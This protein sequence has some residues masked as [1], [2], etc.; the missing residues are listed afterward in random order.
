MQ[1][2][3][4]LFQA[5]AHPTRRAVL[6]CLP[7]RNNANLIAENFKSTTELLTLKN[8]KNEQQFAI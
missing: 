2:G 8:R 3:R 4:N 5:I 6:A 7:H 1:T